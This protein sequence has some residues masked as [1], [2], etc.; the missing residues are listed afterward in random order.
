MKLRFKCDYRDYHGDFIKEGQIVDIDYCLNKGV[1]ISFID[2]NKKQET[3][4]SFQAVNFC[5]ELLKYPDN[6]FLSKDDKLNVC[7]KCKI[8]TRYNSLGKKV[9]CQNYV[10]G[11][12][13]RVKFNEKGERI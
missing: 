3:T 1:A 8:L 6:L 10:E 9:L 2:G 11:F 4:I 7:S 5:T 12:K 13:C